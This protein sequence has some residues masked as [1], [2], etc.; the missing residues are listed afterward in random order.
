MLR[1]ALLATLLAGVL[2]SLPLYG[3]TSP[4]AVTTGDT[5][6]PAADTTR[7]ALDA[8]R[9]RWQAAGLDDYRFVY[10]VS[11]FCPE[12]FRGP[13]TLTVR[14]GA[15][16]EA[17]F[18][19]RPMDPTDARFKTVA[20]LLEVVGAAFDRGAAS[21]RVTYDEAFGY[22]VAASIDYEARAADDEMTFWVRDLVPLG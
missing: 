1:L 17:V 9:A 11:C 10:E 4:R 12:D 8:A 14:D 19:G 7:A 2:L 16:T 18:Q 21:V 6:A 15:V 13:F 5:G 3:C 22:P 20:A